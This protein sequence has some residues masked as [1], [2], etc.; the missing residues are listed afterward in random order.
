MHVQPMVVQWRLLQDTLAVS[1]DHFTQFLS[2]IKT[3]FLQQCL[4][5]NPDPSE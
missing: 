4:G 2:A 5:D 1:I 3:E